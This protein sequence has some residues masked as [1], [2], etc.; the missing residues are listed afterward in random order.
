MRVD[1][2]KS[3]IHQA[4]ITQCILDYEGSLGIDP[5][6]MDEVGFLPYEKILVVNATNGERLETYIIPLQRGCRDFTLNGAAAR[7]GA[8]GDMITIMSFGS[9]ELEEAQGFKPK[10]IVMDANNNIARRRGSLA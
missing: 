5:D 1:L 2:C 7:R 3:K 8:V 10:I 9:F 6:L 4:R